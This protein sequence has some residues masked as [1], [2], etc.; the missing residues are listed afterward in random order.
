MW[1]IHANFSAHLFGGTLLGRGNMLN[2]KS[3]SYQH[4]MRFFRA[5]VDDYIDL[6]KLRR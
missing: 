1:T 4:I 5:K 2:L 3:R 6:P